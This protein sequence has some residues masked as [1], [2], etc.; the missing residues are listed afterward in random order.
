MKKSSMILALLLALTMAFVFVGCGGDTGTVDITK[1]AVVTDPPPP[2]PAVIWKL[3]D[4]LDVIGVGT[5][6]DSTNPDA[7]DGTPLTY[8]GG[9]KLTIATVDGALVLKIQTADSW[10][11]GVDIKIGTGAENV[12]LKVGDI[13]KITGKSSALGDGKKIYFRPDQAVYGDDDIVLVADADTAIAWTRTI[14]AGDMGKINGTDDAPPRF[15][16]GT[17]GDSGTEWTITEITV[18]RDVD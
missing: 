15:R 13:L 11:G 3:S 5:Y 6:D 2:P 1:G 8:V 12:D 17:T 14:T 18:S 4:E 9:S 10:G 7:L 16:I